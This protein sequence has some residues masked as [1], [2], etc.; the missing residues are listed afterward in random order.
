M[1]ISRHAVWAYIQSQEAKI[2]ESVP[3]YLISPYILYLRTHLHGSGDFC[4]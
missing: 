4:N 3:V 2:T 1:L